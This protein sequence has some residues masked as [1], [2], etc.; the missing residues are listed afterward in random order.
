MGSA[1]KLLEAV[2]EA[3]LADDDPCLDHV[4]ALACL[5]TRYGSLLGMFFC[6]RLSPLT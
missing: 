6:R 5:H 4:L 1:T 3:E 2:T